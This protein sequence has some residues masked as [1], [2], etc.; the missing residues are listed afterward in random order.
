M[1]TRQIVDELL[2]KAKRVV[3][4]HE[5]GDKIPTVFRGEVKVKHPTSRVEET[6][7]PGRVY[8]YDKKA[9]D[10]KASSFD[11]GK[12][13]TKR[14]PANAKHEKELKNASLNTNI[15]ALLEKTRSYPKV[16]GYLRGID[17]QRI[18]EGKDVPVTRREKAVRT[19]DE[20]SAKKLEA[21]NKSMDDQTAEYF[22]KC[23]SH[24]LFAETEDGLESKKKEPPK[25]KDHVFGNDPDDKRG[26]ELEMVKK[27]EPEAY[28]S[29]ESDLVKSV[30]ALL[31]KAYYGVGSVGGKMSIQ[32]THKK[33]PAHSKVSKPSLSEERKKEIIEG[34]Q[35]KAASQASREGLH[36]QAAKIRS[37][38]SLD[39]RTSDL[40][41]SLYDI[42]NHKKFARQD[43]DAGIDAEKEK[44]MNNAEDLKSDIIDT[45]RRLGEGTVD[46]MK[47]KSIDSDLEKGA[48]K[49]QWIKDQEA[50][51]EDPAAVPGSI[52]EGRSDKG[53][54]VPGSKTL[55]NPQDS[56]DP[57]IRY[58]SL[59]DRTC[60]LI[61]ALTSDRSKEIHDAV[62]TARMIKH[63]IPEA[64]NMKVKPDDLVR[65]VRT[66]NNMAA[67]RTQ[68]S[69]CDK[70]QD[71][72]FMT[73]GARVMPI[74]P[75]GDLQ[76]LSKDDNPSYHETDKAQERVQSG[77][78]E[79]ER[80]AK[81]RISDLGA[82]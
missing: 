56:Q 32:G 53:K 61:K 10:I 21:K 16:E 57:K 54:Y 70:W 48:F 12:M 82:E 19:A 45:E 4:Q 50:K 65:V 43:P 75:G 42:V 29:E 24:V 9:G 40:A 60:D 67:A 55:N 15:D 8:E 44:K 7:T 74:G 28:K 38:K 72:P 20:N 81:K 27:K 34:S 68:K 22:V 17:K 80:K 26:S 25:K 13:E 59:D 62:T 30:D 14:I 5:A 33:E 37:E 76:D 58:K 18:D 46:P 66:H 1:M 49:D 73:K 79:R 35:K 11:T 78:A 77:A 41:K 2:N 64:K 23:H 51:G 31:E 47:K 36:G 71:S 63:D 39:E 69:I 6:G 52:E 3:T